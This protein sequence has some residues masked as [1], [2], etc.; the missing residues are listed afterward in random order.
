MVILDMLNERPMLTPRIEAATT[1][2]GWA[3]LT[4]ADKG[5]LRPV[6]QGVR[7]VLRKAGLLRSHN[8]FEINALAHA[9]YTGVAK[10]R[11]E[12]VSGYEDTFGRMDAPTGTETAGE[13]G[14]RNSHAS[15]YDERPEGSAVRGL[16]FK[17][18][19]PD[20]AMRRQMARDRKISE[21]ATYHYADHERPTDRPTF[22][23]YPTPAPDQVRAHEAQLA[24]DR[25]LSGARFSST[26]RITPEDISEDRTSFNAQLDRYFS[27]QMNPEE[28]VRLRHT[29]NV[30][31]MLGAQPLEMVIDQETLKKVL[32]DKHGLDEA[33][34]RQLF[35]QLHDPLMVFR[36]KSSGLVIMTELMQDGKTI[37]AAIH[38]G[39]EQQQHVVN[40]IASIYGKDKDGTFASWIRQG[41]ARYWDKAKALAWFRSRGL[42][43]PKEG[44]I[45]GSEGSIADKSDLVKWQGA[46]I[47]H[48]SNRPRGLR[49]QDI[50]QPVA[51]PE[52]T[53][54]TRDLL[55]SAPGILERLRIRGGRALGVFHGTEGANT[56][57]GRVDLKADIF[58]GPQLAAR[59]TR[60]MAT[61]DEMDA[62]RDDILKAS[63]VNPDELVI[64]RAKN[65][66]TFGLIAYARDHN[67]AAQILGHEI[68]HAAD[69]LEEGSLKRGNIL[70]HIAA[71]HKYM[72]STV[73]AVNAA[74]T[75]EQRADMRKDVEKAVR[76]AGT[77][78]SDK[79]F[80]GMVAKEMRAR[81][82]AKGLFDKGEIRDELKALTH[83]WS[84]FDADNVPDSYKSYRYSAPELY[85]EALSV[86]FNNPEQLAQ[87][88]P[89]FWEAFNEFADARPEVKAALDAIQSEI[90]AG[91]TPA[92]RLAR[93]RQAMAMDE[94]RRA[95]IAGERA[96]LAA[97]APTGPWPRSGGH[98]GRRWTAGAIGSCIPARRTRRHCCCC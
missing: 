27:G 9:M 2:E 13:T 78:S 54:L 10:G 97:T 64:R 88:A 21:T 65:G 55:G 75:P 96:A 56:P 70:G 51:L 61:K 80:S 26:R 59:R 41:L 24:R 76:A 31:Q 11:A 85:A 68:G 98:S 71:L 95:E 82:A 34:L 19:K 48:S 17:Q 39:K 38:L 40:D 72:S 83:W 87:R 23:R 84:P 66:K 25:E 6:W 93:E 46:D 89:R 63:N 28:M 58:V 32:H 81:I 43:L 22:Q 73:G 16:N 35:D 45:Q 3:R 42:Q 44:T 90:K 74:M 5:L 12:A 60:A 91:N 18:G 50:P 77:P 86:M 69:W 36:S 15:A 67:Y 7:R 8:D 20:A 79:A 92:A 14:A 29:P 47:R 1:P 37:V 30:L 4:N 57:A 49:V 52:L 62:F 53:N 33:T 94:K